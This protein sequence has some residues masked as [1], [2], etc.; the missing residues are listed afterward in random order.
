M[1]VG[2]YHDL[3]GRHWRVTNELS[4]ELKYKFFTGARTY[5][6]SE[7][8]IFSVNSAAASISLDFAEI[9]VLNLMFRL[10]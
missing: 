3:V 4:E 7:P 5:L 8:E 2:H 6:I 9:T 10:R 1:L